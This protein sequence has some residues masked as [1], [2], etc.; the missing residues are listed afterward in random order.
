MAPALPVVLPEFFRFLLLCAIE[1]L[2]IFHSRRVGSAD[3]STR[4]TSRC[5]NRFNPQCTLAKGR[6][7][8]SKLEETQGILGYKHFKTAAAGAR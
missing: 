7:V 3:T 8:K 4:P 1:S 2:A 6:S 5:E